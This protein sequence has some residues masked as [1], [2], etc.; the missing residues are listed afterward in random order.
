MKKLT[1]S[2]V[3]ASVLAGCSAFP[4]DYKRDVGVSDIR[5]Q[6][7][8][9]W[10]ADPAIQYVQ[11]ASGA[12]VSKHF[13]LPSKVANRKLVLNFAPGARVTLGDLI[14]V[15]RKQGFKVVSRLGDHASDQ[16]LIRKFDGTLGDFVDELSHVQNIAY[17]FRNGILFVQDAN[18]YS[19]SLPQHEELLAQVAKSLTE[20]GATDVRTDLLAGMVHF[21]AKPDISAYVSE[22]LDR[23]AENSAMVR[24]QIA[25]VTV[26]LNRNMDRGLDWGSLA[27]RFGTKDL[28]PGNTGS[29]QFN[30]NAGGSAL[31]EA[32][33]MGQSVAFNGAAGI[34]YVFNSASFSLT[35]AIRALSTFGDARTE[36]NVVLDT[37][38]GM[39]VRISSGNDIPY[40]KSIGSSTS[41]GGSISGST[42]TEVIRSGLELQVTPN[43]DSADNSVIT[44]VKVNMSSL[45]GFRELQAGNNLGTLSQPEMQNLEFENVGRLRAGETIVVGGI[46]YDQLSTNYT[47]LPFLEDLPLGSKAEKIDKKAIYIVVRPT[48]VIFTRNAKELTEKE[49][50]RQASRQRAAQ[51]Q[52]AQAG[53]LHYTPEP[54]Q[55]RQV[56]AESGQI[57]VSEPERVPTRAPVTRLEQ[58]Q[59]GWAGSALRSSTGAT[60][61]LGTPAPLTE[62]ITV[63]VQ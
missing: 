24:L 14:S 63:E 56:Q 21:A 8:E 42:Q 3:A 32:M 62:S 4:E 55:L 39:P 52:Q 27:A 46:T 40:V 26:G 6:Y 22:Y 51:A 50:Q 7:D 61:N 5:E 10:S 30:P 37:V 11:S 25:V 35:A 41:S 2:L 43:F 48:V 36:Q 38:S 45:V 15:M 47:G 29:A 34:G 33:L 28:S 53:A 23:I 18:R 16:L 20:M 13:T 19:V 44:T 12:S 49:A 57:Q 1:L 9:V 54:E 59:P 17:E 31:S 60:L 58:V